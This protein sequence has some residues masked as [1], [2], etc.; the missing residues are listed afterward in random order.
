MLQNEAIT[1]QIIAAAIH[2][3]RTLGPGLLESV[4]E[5]CLSHE[6]TKR[7]LSVRRQVELPVIYDGV[8]IDCGFRID[9]LVEG[10]VVVELKCA[11]KVHPVHEAQL[12]T[13]LRLS[14][15]STGLLLNFYTKVL[16]DGILRRVV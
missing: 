16:K 14:G 3:H 12:M 1:D 15:H 8:R 5:A 2:V 4:Y 9:I 13:Y 10:T 7:G 6:L 11:E